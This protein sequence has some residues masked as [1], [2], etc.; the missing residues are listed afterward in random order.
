VVHGNTVGGLIYSE[1]DVV[2][3]QNNT[4]GGNLQIV[5]PTSCVEVDNIVSGSSTGCP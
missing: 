1:A 3:I 4:I 2:S 5:S